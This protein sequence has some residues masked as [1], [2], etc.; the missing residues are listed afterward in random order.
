MH[1]YI[2]NTILQ[3]IMKIILRKQGMRNSK[4]RFNWLVLDKAGSFHFKIQFTEH[5]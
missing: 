1:V 4:L 2:F 5:G 3:I